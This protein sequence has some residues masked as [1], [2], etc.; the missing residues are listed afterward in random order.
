MKFINFYISN[1]IQFLIVLEGKPGCEVGVET[2][3]D[4]GF[5]SSLLKKKKGFI[6]YRL[7]EA[8]LRVVGWSGCNTFFFSTLP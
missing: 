5:F 3:L 6:Q 7:V 8:E 4:L 1:F 2:G